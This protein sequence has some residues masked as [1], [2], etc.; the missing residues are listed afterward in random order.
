MAVR[1]L[2]LLALVGCSAD[3]KDK[4]EDPVIGDDDTG[5]TDTDD[6]VDTD[7]TDVDDTDVDDTGE[8]DTVPPVDADGDGSTADE[9]C[10]DGD[11]TVFPGAPELCDG[12]DNNCDGRFD[13][14]EDADEDGLADCEDY[15][16]VYASPGATGDGRVS[17]PMG[18]IQDAI[19]LA[20]A[21]GCYEV[22]AYQGT[23]YENVNWYGYPVNA[24]SVSGAALTTIDG[25]GL[26]SV[27]AF[28]TAET[29]DARIY[30][31]TLTNGGGDEG[32]GIRVRYAAPTI[33][34]NVITGNV[35]NVSPWLAGGIRVYEGDAVII[36]NE[37]TSN[38][39]GY[40]GPENGSDGGGVNVRGGSPYIAGNVIADNTAGDG[41]GLW[42]AYTDAIIVNNLIAG[43]A[44]MDD[45][46]TAG[47]QGG[48]INVQI[49][50]PTG[51]FISGNIVTDNTASMYG[52]GIVTYEAN[53]LYPSA[54]I[55]NNTI[56]FNEVTDTDYGAGVLQWRRT[57]PTLT[58]NIIAYNNGVGVYSEDDVDDTYTY[59]LVYGNGTNYSGLSGSGAGNLVADPLFTAVT[60][61]ADWT[62][63][64][65]SLR[66][67]SPAIDAG[68]PGD[69]D[70]DGSRADLG[71]YGGVYG[72]W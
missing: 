33:E 69:A 13:I 61:D 2:V 9:D 50:G 5:A 63:D 14:D 32:P 19:D 38:D 58:N 37:I 20:G 15:C 31:F 67:G 60:N 10:D 66:S 54:Q 8:T 48:G 44:A 53:D 28:E 45:D 18:F 4:T 51:P 30:G 1:L 72:G 55:T 35:A 64:D 34:G 39:A 3:L 62:N 47:G 6:T 24:E 68:N 52:G 65:F 29:E 71:A 36:N 41:G 49:S 16:P 21:S 46:L 70:P 57:T 56:T 23:Y 11:A 59:N 26:D 43:N 25:Q 17:D 27:V 7:D 42:I 22:R 40:G 12:R